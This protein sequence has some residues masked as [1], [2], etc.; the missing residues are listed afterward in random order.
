MYAEQLMPLIRKFHKNEKPVKFLE[1]GL[2]CFNGNHYGS[3]IDIWK[4]IFSKKDELWISDYDEK[5]IDNA[6]KNG[7]LDGVNWLKGNQEFTHVMAQWVEKS[8]GGFNV[9]I[10]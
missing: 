9:I 2:G 1:I 3:G 10:E 5:C 8:K 6:I 7:T 4:H